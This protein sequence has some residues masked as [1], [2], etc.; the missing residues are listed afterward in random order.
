MKKLD[1]SDRKLPWLSKSSRKTCSIYR[2]VSVTM[3]LMASQMLQ[4]RSPWT[5]EFLSRWPSSRWPNWS[6]IRLVSSQVSQQPDSE[7]MWEA[8]SKRRPCLGHHRPRLNPNR[9][10]RSNLM[11]A[12]RSSKNS[13]DLAKAR[14]RVW[15]SLR[16]TNSLMANKTTHKRSSRSTG[17]PLNRWTRTRKKSMSKNSLMASWTLMKS[18][19]TQ[20]SSTIVTLSALWLSTQIRARTWGI[21]PPSTLWLRASLRSSWL[22]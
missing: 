1:R 14:K 18:R 5:R 17:K 7:A 13:Q 22:S 4:A 8:H 16:R 19:T 10:K 12:T 20:W 6:M 9:K 11:L 21:H 2:M 15:L 3:A